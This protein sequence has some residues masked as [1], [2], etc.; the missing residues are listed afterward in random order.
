LTFVLHEGT[1]L[2]MDEQPAPQRR[3]QRRGPRKKVLKGAR[4]VFSNGWTTID[5]TVRNMSDHG[6]LVVFESSV[7]VPSQF[8][9]VFDDGNKRE[10]VVDRRHPTWVGVSFRQGSLKA[11]LKQIG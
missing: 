3:E 8:T 11:K 6:A 9:L 2:E 4:A 7:G 5:C 10:C 1:E